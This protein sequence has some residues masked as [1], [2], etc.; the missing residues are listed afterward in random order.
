M[1]EFLGRLYENVVYIELRRRKKPEQDINY[2]KSSSGDET[3]FVIRE[4][5]KIIQ[6]IQVCY[7]LELENTAKREIEGLVKA[8][9]EFDFNEG[10]IVSRN[11][12]KEENIDGV[13]IHY[14][15]LWKF[16]L[17]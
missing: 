3:D 13:K 8:A 15:P 6:L 11:I 4:G 2:W 7:D 12:E 9:K 10:W 1:K 14:V 5:S 16:L 17:A